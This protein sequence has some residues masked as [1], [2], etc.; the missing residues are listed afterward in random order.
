MLL[1]PDQHIVFF[2]DSVTDCD[3]DRESLGDPGLGLGYVRICHAMLHAWLPQSRFRITNRGV[4]GDR[5]YD[6]EERLQRD[7]LDIRPDVV[8]ILIGIND[9]WQRYGTHKR[10]SPVPEF[11]AS[12]RRILTKIKTGTQSTIIICE[13]FLLPVPDDRLA[14]REDLDPRRMAIRGLA[15]EF[16]TEFLPLDTIFTEAA[17]CQPAEVWAPDGVHPSTAGHGLIAKAWLELV[18]AVA[19]ARD[20]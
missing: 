2:G 5:I 13:P 17:R 18:Q 16:Q 1:T 6:L 19:S 9:T 10:T 14:W 4:S 3:R 8:S 7:V 20:Y 15:E 12:Y 11:I